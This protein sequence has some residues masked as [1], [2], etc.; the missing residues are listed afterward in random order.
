MRA[1]TRASVTRGRSDDTCRIQA[2]VEAMA[3]LCRVCARCQA[4]AS[5]DAGRGNHQLR[6]GARA[7]L[8]GVG[9]QVALGRRHHR[10]GHVASSGTK[11][12][13][14]TCAAPARQRLPA[15]THHPR[16]AQTSG[17]AVSRR[18]LV[19]L[20]GAGETT[21]DGCRYHLDHHNHVPIHGMR[22]ECMLHLTHGYPTP[23]TGARLPEC[24]AAENTGEWRIT[25]KIQSK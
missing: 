4:R 14:S 21:C 24:I 1:T 3:K 25:C 8:L 23:K 5:S 10:P 11:A 19:T 7:A 17:V 15:R 20:E 9:G 22:Y 13:A 6:M 12:C 2:S 16:R 18:I